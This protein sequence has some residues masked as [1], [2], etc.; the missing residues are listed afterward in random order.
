M[1]VTDAVELA[2]ITSSYIESVRAE[3]VRIVRCGPYLWTRLTEERSHIDLLF[4]PGA[5]CEEKITNVVSPRL[6]TTPITAA[7]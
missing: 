3:Q 6:L 7:V 2:R 1:I 5:A 4:N